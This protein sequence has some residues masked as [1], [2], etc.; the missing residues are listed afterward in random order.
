MSLAVSFKLQTP[1]S[2]PKLVFAWV[3]W[4]LYALIGLIMWRQVLSPRQTA[5][6]AAVGF[7]IPFIS[8]WLMTKHG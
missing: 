5:W 1:I 6:L 7:V 2:N 3:V 4:A 8:L